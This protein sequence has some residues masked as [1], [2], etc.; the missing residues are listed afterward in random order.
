MFLV[1]RHCVMTLTHGHKY[2]VKVTVELHG[3]FLSG[4]YILHT[5]HIGCIEHW[6]KKS[7][8]CPLCRRAAIVLQQFAREVCQPKMRAS[9]GKKVS[10]QKVV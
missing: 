3:I 10:K 9:Q 1:V 8:S 4:Q 6:M 7:D 5:F 2:N